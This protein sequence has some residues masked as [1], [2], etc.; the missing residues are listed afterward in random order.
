VRTYTV[1]DG[2]DQVP[3][4]ARELGLDVLL[5]VWIGRDREHNEGEIDLAIKA[6]AE[7]RTAI[8]A[9]VVGNEV[10]L[11]REQTR[12]ELAVLIR[13]VAEATGLPVTY[14][15]VWGYWLKHKSLADSV[16][17]VTVH[18]LPYWDDE[19]VAIDILM[20]YVDALCT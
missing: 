19:P 12:E 6:A 18:I 4:V 7:N 16:S 11:R 2:F 9:I 3:A 17:F 13:R 14:A 15:D 10:L 1:S 20:P 8:R 5:G